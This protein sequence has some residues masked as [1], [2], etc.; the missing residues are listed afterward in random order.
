VRFAT[1]DPDSVKSLAALVI[2]LA[3]PSAALAEDAQLV[4]REVALDGARTLAASL[5]AFNLVGLHWQGPGAVSFR[6]RSLAGR[7]SAW[8]NAIPEPLDVPDA[9]TSEGRSALAWRLGNPFWV[10]TANAIQ[11]RVRGRVTRLRAH[12]VTSQTSAVPPRA[13]SIASSPPLTVR[14]AWGANEAIKRA[15]PTYA[16]TLRFSVVHHTAGSNSYTA[17]QSA[18]IVRAIQTYHVKGNGWNDIGY[19]FLV[20]KY[21]R[22][23]EGRFGGV[24]RNVV[25]AHAEGF[26]TGSVGVAL[27]GTYGSAKPTAKALDAIAALLAWRLDVGHVDPLARL[28]W[29]SGGNARFPSGTP[30]PLAVVS[31]HRDTGP[32]TCPGNALYAQLS[33]IARRAAEIGL[34]KLYDP[35]VQGRPGT[36]VRFTARLSSARPWTVRVMDEVG[37]TVGTGTGDGTAIDWT[38]DATLATARRYTYAIEAGPDVRPATGVIG[39]AATAGALSLTGAGARPGTFT[40]NGD[41]RADSTV[42]TYTLSQAALVTATLRDAFGQTLATLFTLQKPAGR[43]SFRF[44]ASGV[45]DGR[46]TVVIV[47]RASNGREVRAE[48]PIVVDRT[49]AAFAVTPSVFSPNGDRR[50]DELVFRFVLAAPA[51]VV[52]RLANGQTLYET[53]LTPGPQELRW[54]E[55]LRD[56]RYAAVLE[57]AGPFGTRAQ[58]ARFAVDT[59]SP[60]LRVVSAPR[61]RFSVDEL[62]MVVGTIGGQR[63]EAR[64]GPGRFTLR[65]PAGRIA[66][67]AWDAAG[68]RT[69][70][71]HP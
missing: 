2:A 18:A 51:H 13:L 15:G 26:N 38:W 55:R 35:V 61:R 30:V 23:F 31:G 54:G 53:D 33:A 64:V 40:P 63:V 17:A 69:R 8:R 62:V 29:I 41:S 5:P 14:S 7:W 56:G 59:T 37:G 39:Q 42:I 47:A 12:F 67:T 58:T 16:Q 1:L 32:T 19:N 48:V 65:A 50:L 9:G 21:G 44:T 4:T 66:V 36:L 34:P 71:R 22:V 10:G 27:L 11:Y 24:E 25:G 6:T 49:L 45:A 52:L 20:D 3:F 57:A 28:S 70:L 68:N 60:K 46:Y 43:H